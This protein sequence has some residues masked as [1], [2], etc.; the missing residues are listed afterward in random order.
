MTKRYQTVLFLVRHGE[1]NYSYNSARRLD[2][3]RQ[4]TE[5]GKRQAV[6]VGR[7][8]KSFAPV[9]IYSSPLSRCLESAE[10]IRREAQVAAP[11]QESRKLV[12]IYSDQP[13]RTA[14]E[15]GASFYEQVLRDH[16]GDQVV[17]ITHQYIIGYLIADFT[18]IEYAD[19]PCQFADIYRLVFAG[20]KLVEATRLQPAR[21]LES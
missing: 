13:H 9:K 14:G 5:R 1:T 19:V 3:Q 2:E 20:D 6:A 21:N 18:G 11:V 17:A 15:R 16:P 10:L 7:Y 8:L 4:L 12:E